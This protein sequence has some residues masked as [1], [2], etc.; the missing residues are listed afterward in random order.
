[1]FQDKLADVLGVSRGDV[2]QEVVGTTKDE[3]LL[4]LGQVPEF[5]AK[6]AHQMPRA[7]AKPNADQGL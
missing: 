7:R 5:L 2:D 1:M 4:D 6:G 3:E